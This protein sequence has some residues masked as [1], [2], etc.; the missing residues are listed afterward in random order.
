MKNITPKKTSTTEEVPMT[1]AVR[2]GLLHMCIERGVEQVAHYHV[3]M[4]TLLTQARK[5]AGPGGWLKW[6]ADNE[7]TLGFGERQAQR[8]LRETP[9]LRKSDMEANRLAVA[10]HRAKKKVEPELSLRIGDGSPDED[11]DAP[12]DIAAENA[13]DLPAIEK[14]LGRPLPEARPATEPAEPDMNH[15]IDTLEETIS[16]ITKQQDD[17][18]EWHRIRLRE[19]RDSLNAVIAKTPGLSMKQARAD[20]KAEQEA[21][22]ATD[23]LVEEFIKERDAGLGPEPVK[24][25]KYT[26]PMFNGRPVELVESIAEKRARL[27]K[28]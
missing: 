17:V 19:Q 6:L 10:K 26:G 5:D 25:Y 9:D 20:A 3:E 16:L 11:D 13:R 14:I 7:E 23:A 2:C 4:C 1:M 24:K 27:E 21:E 15:L 22:D 28:K 8:Y 18:S 12:V